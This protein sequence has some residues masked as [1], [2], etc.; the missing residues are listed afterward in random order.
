MAIK[1]TL[2][3][4]ALGCSASA[5]IAFADTP[6]IIINNNAPAA[7]A[8][9]NNNQNNNTG[10]NG[11]SSVDPNA[12]RPGVYYQTNPNGGTDTQYTTGD[13]TPYTADTNCNNNNNVVAQPYVYVPSPPVPGPR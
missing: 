13:K 4:F 2:L 5:F 1:Y 11:Q 3:A 10:C 7:P 12:Q 6:P 9:Q 8:P